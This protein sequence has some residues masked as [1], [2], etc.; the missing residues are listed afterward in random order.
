M[1][2]RK[3]VLAVDGSSYSDEAFNCKCMNVSNILNISNSCYFI[4]VAF[5]IEIS[6]EEE[7]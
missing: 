1:A 4:F 6:L 7:E 2:Q 3:V 5:T